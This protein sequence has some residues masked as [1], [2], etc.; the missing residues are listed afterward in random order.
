MQGKNIQPTATIFDKEAR[1]KEGLTL[2]KS[3][4]IE[5]PMAPPTVASV[6]YL[7]ARTRIVAQ[8]SVCA[9]GSWQERLATMAAE[10]QPVRTSDQMSAEESARRCVLS[11]TCSPPRKKPSWAGD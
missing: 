6:M 4:G 8:E 9:C 2:R 5:V 10:R 7:T 1:L 3:Q 11:G